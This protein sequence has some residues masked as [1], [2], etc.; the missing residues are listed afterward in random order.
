LRI[1]NLAGLDTLYLQENN[2]VDVTCIEKS[3]YLT[4]LTDVNLDNQNMSEDDY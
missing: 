2:I 1:V 4:N 3:K